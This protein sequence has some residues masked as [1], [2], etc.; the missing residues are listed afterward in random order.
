MNSELKEGEVICSP[1]K[2]TGVII[3]TEK[4]GNGFYQVK[5][6]CE[7]CNGDGKLDWIENITGKR[8]PL[9][10]RE[11]PTLRQWYFSSSF[12]EEDDK[13]VKKSYENIKQDMDPNYRKRLERKIAYNLSR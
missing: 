10:K 9:E 13:P 12:E 4:R 3:T 6:F 2:G 5:T 1:C 7:K 11:I 8:T